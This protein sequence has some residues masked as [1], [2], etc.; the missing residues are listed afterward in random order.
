MKWEFISDSYPMIIPKNTNILR[1]KST[2]WENSEDREGFFHATR[3]HACIHCISVKQLDCSLLHLKQTKFISHESLRI[4]DRTCFNIHVIEHRFWYFQRC[5]SD[6]VKYFTYAT[7]FNLHVKYIVLF[8]KI[9]RRY[10]NKIHRD[11]LM[12]GVFHVFCSYCNLLATRSTAGDGSRQIGSSVANS[13]WLSRWFVS[14]G[15]HRCPSFVKL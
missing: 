14:S 4:S 1:I 12:R 9:T 5:M 13:N 3:I 11:L 2:F 15:V 10:A 7:I 6:Q 8:L